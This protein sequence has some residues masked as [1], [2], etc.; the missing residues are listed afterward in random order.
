[1]RIFLLEDDP[2]MAECLTLAC[3]SA[4]CSPEISTFRDAYAAIAALDAGLPDLILLNVLLNGP[5]GFT[6]LNEL[7]S[8]S[9]TARIP[10][11]II[12]SLDLAADELEHYGVRQILHKETM[13]PTLLRAAIREACHAA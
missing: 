5:D 2:I 13:T 9:D 6:F 3:Q 12:T 8:Y 7:I 11:I 10:V 1:M 4:A